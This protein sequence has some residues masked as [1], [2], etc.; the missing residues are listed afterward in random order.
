M[1]WKRKDLLGIRELD[2]AEITLL[3]DTAASLR[4]IGTREIKK[5]PT[6][7]GKTIV[8]LFYEPST[9]TR[10]SFE[11]AGKWLSA[12]VVNFSASTSSIGKGETLLDTA[13]NIEAM[14]PDVVVVRHSSSGAVAAYNYT[15]A[16]TRYRLTTIAG[17]SIVDAAHI[18]QFADSRNNDP[19]NGLAL[20]KNAHWLFDNGLWTLDED[21]RVR[22]AKGEFSEAGLEQ[23]L[24]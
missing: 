17:G 11:I 7:R 5:V 22:V 15:C 3:I 18:H 9:R 19:R 21:Y 10:T 6:L 1:A 12:D 20:S 23:H 8:N 14:S 24:L 2:P 4:E 13:R 16:L